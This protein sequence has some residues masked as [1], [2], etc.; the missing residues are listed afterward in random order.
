SH[1]GRGR[2]T[3]GKARRRSCPIARTTYFSA[4]RHSVIGLLIGKWWLMRHQVRER[5]VFTHCVIHAEAATNYCGF[6]PRHA[7]CETHARRKRLVEGKDKS[8][9]KS[10]CARLN[11]GLAGKCF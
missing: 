7:Q 5:S 6:Q 2:K 10:R 9:G 1:R 3:R 11:L 8:A 4:Y